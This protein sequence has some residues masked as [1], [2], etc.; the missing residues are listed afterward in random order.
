MT[1][2]KLIASWLTATAN[3]LAGYLWAKHGILWGAAVFVGF[4]V[5]IFS[6][7]GFIVFP[8]ERPHV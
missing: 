7:Y 8:R 4:Y 6:V 5:I 2:A 3:I 1:A